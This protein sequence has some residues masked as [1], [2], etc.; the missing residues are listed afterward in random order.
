MALMGKVNGGAEHR[1]SPSTLSTLPEI[2]AA[3]YSLDEEESALSESLSS[4]VSNK[5]PIESSLSNLRSLHSQLDELQG[6]ATY[7][8][9]NVSITAKTARRVGDRVRLLDEE[10][11]RVREA[12]E[13]VGLVM[14]LKVIIVMK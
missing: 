2:L 7:L 8:E 6:E 5:A 11:R 14:E 13:R 4:L 9:T 1:P 3:L 10:M 12:A